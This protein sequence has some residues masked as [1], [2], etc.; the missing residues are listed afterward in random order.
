[1]F[2]FFPQE[3]SV[4]LENYHVFCRS[5]SVLPVALCRT[6]PGFIHALRLGFTAILSV[7]HG[8]CQYLCF[9]LSCQAA[10]CLTCALPL[11]AFSNIFGS[12]SVI[13]RTTV[14][15]GYICKI[16]SAFLTGELATPVAAHLTANGGWVEF[17]PSSASPAPSVDPSNPKALALPALRPLAW[18]RFSTK[19]ERILLASHLEAEIAMHGRQTEFLHN[20]ELPWWLGDADIDHI[21]DHWRGV[22]LMQYGRCCWLQMLIDN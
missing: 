16:H 17:H 20:H 13:S 12:H 21:A 9:M 11:L 5:A 15:A 7:A 4:S 19:Q 6:A 22:G 2:C 3:T 8:C 10:L 14:L 1:M 18:F